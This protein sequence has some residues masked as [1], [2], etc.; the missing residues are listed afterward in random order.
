MIYNW[1]L[2]AFGKGLG[3]MGRLEIPLRRTAPLALVRRI[4]RSDVSDDG[5]RA[6]VMEKG[7]D[8]E[9]CGYLDMFDVV[10]VY[11]RDFVVK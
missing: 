10:Q 3:D 5:G 6:G 8:E 11:F 4:G 2:G 9:E 7:D 1:F